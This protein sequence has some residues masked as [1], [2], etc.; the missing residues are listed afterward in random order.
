MKSKKNQLVD[1]YLMDGC[2]RCKYGGTVSCK[3]HNW[4]EELL[5][6]REIALSTGLIE[7]IKWGVPVYT[8]KEKNIINVSA[9]K[10]SAN[11]GF[12]KGVL[13][14]DPK[15]ILQQQGNIQSGR[16]LKFTTVDEIKK[17]SEIII[18]YIYEAISVEEKGM[19]VASQ[20]ITAPIPIELTDAFREDSIFKKAFY[21]LTPGRQRG[22]IIYFSQPKQSQTR[23]S[24][25][26]KY[27]VQIMNG[28]GLHDKYK[29]K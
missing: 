3:V 16:I 17:M 24:R 23:I 7:E 27:K 26:A 2:M 14:S 12:F 9:L 10:N 25:I 15:N 5:L 6:L 20:N 18:S 19:V 1:K 21:D 8:H 11:I 28:I 4:T 29:S 22:Y 13:L